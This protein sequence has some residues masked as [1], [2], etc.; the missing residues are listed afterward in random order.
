M[1]NKND[2]LFIL[3]I[4]FIMIFIM[5]FVLF[6]RDKSLNVMKYNYKDIS[7]ITRYPI[8]HRGLYNSVAPENSMAAFNRAIERG[9]PIELDIRLTKDNKVVVIHDSNLKRLA[10]DKRKV[11]DIT[12]RELAKLKLLGTKEKIPLFNDVLEK[13]DGDVELLIEIKSCENI[14]K[15]LEITNNILKDYKGK[16]AIQSFDKRVI[17]WYEVNNIEVIKGLLVKNQSSLNYINSESIENQKSFDNIDFIS[18]SLAI[19]DNQ[20]IQYLRSKGLKVLTWTIKNTK[21]LD[22]AN[23]Y[24]DNYI[25]ENIN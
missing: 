20:Q 11:E 8:A 18:V 15:L 22:K 1:K 10:N 14:I 7:W 9:Y 21:R 19:I 5:I 6:D 3:I 13:V 12:Y 25:F 24:S 23:K 16:Y 2:K 17:E 4:N